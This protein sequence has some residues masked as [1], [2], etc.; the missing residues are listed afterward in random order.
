MNIGI[1]VDGVLTDMEGYQFKYGKKYFEEQLGMQIKNPKG[2]DIEEIYGCTY[3]QREEFWRKHIW[4]YCLSEPMTEGAA[5]TAAN[6]RRLGHKIIVITG[7]AHT[8]EKGI[9]GLLFRM[10]LRYWLKKN[11]F[12]YDELVFCSEKNSSREKYQV[13]MEK[14]VDIMIDDKPENL[15]MLKPKINV[16][17]YPAIWNREIREL[18]D[19]RITEFREIMNH[20]E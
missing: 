18:D 8:T 19:I 13:C 11:Q 16:L 15:L 5:D 17:C 7:R 12:P 14:R 1:D 6:L 9:T 3:K 2:Y 20:L 4:R 10:M